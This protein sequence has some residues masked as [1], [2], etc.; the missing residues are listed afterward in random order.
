MRPRWYDRV[1]KRRG[2]VLK[3]SRRRDPHAVEYGGYMLA[4]AR[5]NAVVLGGEG[6]PR[7]EL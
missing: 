3:K 7:K 2:Y 4:D 5:L 1:A 6:L